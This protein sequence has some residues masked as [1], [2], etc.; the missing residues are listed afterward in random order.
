MKNINYFHIIILSII[1][2][3][4]QLILASFF[5]GNLIF[6]YLPNALVYFILP[7]LLFKKIAANKKRKALLIFL[8]PTLFTLS[9][10]IH[11]IITEKYF[12]SLPVSIIGIISLFSAYYIHNSKRYIKYSSFFFLMILFSFYIYCNWLIGSDENITNSKFTDEL[13]LID[14][15]N[16]DFS[17]EKNKGKVLVF[18]LW[19]SSCGICFKEFPEFEELYNKYKDD[20]KV[21][22]IVLNLPLKRDSTLNVRK[23]IEKYSF[24][25]LYSQNLKSWDL[26]D[27]NTVPKIIMLDKKGNVRFKGNMSTNKFI[28]YNNFHSLIEK[29]KNE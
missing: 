14:S 15:E 4:T 18:E 6:R 21:E 17:I 5:D 12:A 3:A 23:M 20:P 25:K 1:Y 13:N 19:S 9:V 26:L 7:L 16:N 10:S 2:F 27:N 22:L 24:K 8:T 29:Y 28:V 11:V